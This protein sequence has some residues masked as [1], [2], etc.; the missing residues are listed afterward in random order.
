MSDVPFGVVIKMVAPPNVGLAL[1]GFDCVIV[2]ATSTLPSAAFVVVTEIIP[3]AVAMPST[4]LTAPT[5]PT[6][7]IVTLVLSVNETAPP[8]VAFAANVL[9]VFD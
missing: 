6:L 5:A 2:A 4:S 1:V 7:P 3:V 9:T 8:P